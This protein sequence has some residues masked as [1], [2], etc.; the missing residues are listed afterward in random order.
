MSYLRAI[1]KRI[2]FKEH[3]RF[4]STQENQYLPEDLYYRPFGRISPRYS[5]GTEKDPVPQLSF[6]RMIF[7]LWAWPY[8]L[9]IEIITVLYFVYFCIV[10]AKPNAQ[11]T[12]D[13]IHYMILAVIFLPTVLYACLAWIGTRGLKIYQKAPPILN[14]LPKHPSKAL[15]VKMGHLTTSQ[16]AYGEWTQRANLISIKL[17]ESYKNSWGT[18]ISMLLLASLIFIFCCNMLTN[19]V[20]FQNIF[21]VMFFSLAIIYTLF[22]IWIKNEARRFKI[23]PPFPQPTNLSQADKT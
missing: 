7:L 9:T 10:L 19:A 16:V 22:L 4:P 6:L 21:N 11:A 12:A 3:F 2:F 17:V 18:L 5:L 23:N 15:I 8:V 13:I 20:N 14:V 1:K